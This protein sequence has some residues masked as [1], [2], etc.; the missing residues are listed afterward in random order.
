MSGR[1]VAIVIAG[2]LVCLGGAVAVLFIL[3]NAAR[4]TQ[5]SLDVYV[6]AW[7]LGEPIPVTGLIGL[8][9]VAGFLVCGVLA[10]W[11]GLAARKR[12][13]ALQRQLALGADTA[14]F[15]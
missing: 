2:V 6:A 15:R 3:Q 1:V 14:S 7:Q 5:L 8:S 9:F 13:K 4:T 12:I 11:R 10:A